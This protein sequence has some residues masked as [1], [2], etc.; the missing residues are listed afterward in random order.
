[1]SIHEYK[2]D[3]GEV[4]YRVM[5][6]VNGKSTTRR[7]FRTK[8][9]AKRYENSILTQRDSGKAITSPKLTVEEHLK[10]WY[11]TVKN[12]RTVGENHYKRM[13][14]HINNLIAHLGHL[15]VT[16]LGKVSFDA[17]RTEWRKRWAERTIKAME[18]TL[19]AAM[20]A[21]ARE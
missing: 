12:N 17:L 11:P 7:G 10:E 20:L 2:K 18:I 5:F 14:T 21:K 8:T 13:G 4:C 6:R 3:S 1:M 19:K 9:E 15:R 16:E